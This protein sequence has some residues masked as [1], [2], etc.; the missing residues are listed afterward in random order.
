M[1]HIFASVSHH[2]KLIRRARRDGERLGEIRKG[3]RE[4]VEKGSRKRLEKR[5]RDKKFEAKG[6]LS[7]FRISYIWPCDVAIV[8][9]NPQGMTSW[10]SSIKMWYLQAYRINTSCFIQLVYLAKRR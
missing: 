4:R 5:E 6:G 8:S 9:S 2:D 10:S 7:F 3:R 1:S